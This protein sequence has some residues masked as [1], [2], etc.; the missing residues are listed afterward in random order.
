MITSVFFPV[1]P[2]PKTC[3]LRGAPYRPRMVFAAD[4]C[5][6]LEFPVFAF[7]L[8]HAPGTDPE[9]LGRRGLRS[10]MSRASHFTSCNLL[11][12]APAR[13]I[14]SPI[15]R[16]ER[17]AARAIRPQGRLCRRRRRGAFTAVS[18]L[19]GLV[20]RWLWIKGK[21]IMVLMLPEEGDVDSTR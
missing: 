2:L 14:C 10:R 8:L 20:W 15:A 1:L 5:A 7:Y 9:L 3:L 16:E 19:L 18:T 6:G 4:L 11:I 13:G 17:R 12:G 21:W